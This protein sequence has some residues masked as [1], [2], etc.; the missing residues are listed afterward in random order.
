MQ[1][2]LEK[3]GALQMNVKQ[4]KEILSNYEDNIRVIVRYEEYATRD[5]ENVES[6]MSKDEFCT[7]VV[8]IVA[9]NP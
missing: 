9:E 4:L 7:P 5:I 8:E 6:N 2:Y 1:T 3:V